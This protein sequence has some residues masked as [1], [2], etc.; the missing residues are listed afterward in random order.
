[1]QTETTTSLSKPLPPPL[2]VSAKDWDVA[3]K[4]E[5]RLTL[6]DHVERVHNVLRVQESYTRFLYAVWDEQAVEGSLS[7]DNTEAARLIREKAKEMQIREV[8]DQK[9]AT[10]VKSLGV[11]LRRY[12]Q[13][14]K[15]RRNMVD[16]RIVPDGNGDD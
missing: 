12:N 2:P 10:I 15:Q 7:C 3:R 6:N 16:G 14:R 5:T 4:T 9:L 8:A 1:M 11:V 13:A